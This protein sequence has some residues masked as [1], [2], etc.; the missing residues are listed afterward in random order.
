M[1]VSMTGFVH[2]SSLKQNHPT[3]HTPCG[4]AYDC[5]HPFLFYRIRL[6]IW[7]F[8]CVWQKPDGE[9]ELSPYTNFDPQFNRHTPV[10]PLLSIADDAYEDSFE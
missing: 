1:K 3:I 10:L 2:G 9:D 4:R 5:F 7:A 6:F 8:V